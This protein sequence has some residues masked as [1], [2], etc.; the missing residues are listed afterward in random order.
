MTRR[1]RSV[2]RTSRAPIAARAASRRRISAARLATPRRA[3]VSSRSVMTPTTCGRPRNRSK[4]VPPLK[5]ARRKLT[6]SGPCPAQTATTQLTRSSLLPVP[7][8]PVTMACGP[9]STMSAP[10]GA[11]SLPVPSATWR[12]GPAGGCGRSRRAVAVTAGPSPSPSPHS[13]AAADA[14][15]DERNSTA[16]SA[17]PSA[18]RSVAAPGSS[19]SITVVMPSGTSAPDG[20]V[21]ITASAPAPAPPAEP[22][23]RARR[24]PPRRA[25]CACGSA[26]SARSHPSSPT[27]DSTLGEKRRQSWITR[28]R[29]AACTSG[30][31]PRRHTPRPRATTHGASSN[32]AQRRRKD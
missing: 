19:M 17:S 3:S 4:A 12:P 6:R 16:R 25:R 8:I 26:R 18:V 27:R 15:A 5:S 20:T 14:W 21:Q 30:S 7:V 32:T 10:T 28:A 31:R 9:S 13:S 23:A 11:P 2:S 24:N 29:A 1:G 22:E